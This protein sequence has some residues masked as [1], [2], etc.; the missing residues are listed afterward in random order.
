WAA[1]GAPH[2]SRTERR[3]EAREPRAAR[4]ARSFALPR[5]DAERLHRGSLLGGLLAPSDATPAHASRD[6]DLGDEAFR[7][8]RAAL[9]DQRV[10]GSLAEEPLGQLL[11]LGLV[12]A[13]A[14]RRVGECV[15]R[16]LRLHDP[17]RGLVARVEVDRAEHGFIA[18]REN[19]RLVPAA[20]LL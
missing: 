14:E 19:R 3:R 2:L 12:V 17:T 18:G 10:G 4:A 20:A 7:M 13:L 1:G 9:L 6:G 11:E 16:E 8:V 15:G 5:K